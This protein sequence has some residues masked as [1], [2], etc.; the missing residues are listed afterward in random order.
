MRE[1]IKKWQRLAIASLSGL[2]IVSILGFG[3]FA[4]ASVEKS[5]IVELTEF[6]NSVG[7]DKE[8]VSKTLD[9]LEG[10]NKNVQGMLGGTDAETTHFDY[11]VHIKGDL[12]VDGTNTFTGTNVFSA[13]TTPSKQ[14]YFPIDL[15]MDLTGTSTAKGA[16]Q[17]VITYYTNTGSDK[18]FTWTGYDITTQ[19]GLIEASI[20]CGTS[21][22]V[23]GVAGSSLEATSTAG[24]MAS[25]TVAA[26]WDTGDTWVIRD[27]NSYPGTSFRSG[28]GSGTATASSTAFLL[29]NAEVFFCT[30]T[31]YGATSSAS[32]LSSGGF[33]GVGRVYGQIWAR[34]N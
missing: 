21:T 18:I 6:V 16:T 12:D 7:G 22:W 29:K 34:N 27:V 15:A 2:V 1:K 24:I 5:P 20:Q 13:T 30:W 8:I 28:W 32:F 10:L 33:T 31:P 11:S 23:G 9:Y 26:T 3:V 14:S 25:T 4:Y 17:N 19:L